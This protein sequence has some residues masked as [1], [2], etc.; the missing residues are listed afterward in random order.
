MT[1][2]GNLFSAGATLARQLG[3]T[4]NEAKNAIDGI[5]QEN[6]S[7]LEATKGTL[8]F[9]GDGR[10]DNIGKRV[11]EQ[12]SKWL[13]ANPNATL[14]DVEKE[15]KNATAKESSIEMFDKMAMDRFFQRLMQRRK[16]MIQEMW[17]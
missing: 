16:E 12:M 9:L 4:A 11:S 13:S 7:R 15:A 2:I 3:V 5:L 6:R 8:D 1:A 14:E 10:I 17:G